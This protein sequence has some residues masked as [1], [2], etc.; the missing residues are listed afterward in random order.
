MRY[1]IAIMDYGIGGIDLV[2]RIKLTH[3]RLPILYFS[4]SGYTPY[5]K[6]PKKKLR[7]RV[8]EVIRFLQDKGAQ[9]IVVACH[10]ASSVVNGKNPDVLGI[11][12]L[13]IQS[14][15]KSDVNSVGVI[16]GGRT[17]RAQFYKNELK[18]NGL[19]V[20]QRIAQELSILIE[21]GE[22]DSDYT[23]K[24]LKRIID[25]LKHQEALLLACTH[26]PAL[27]DKIQKM[28]PVLKLID[29]KEEVVS[30]ITEHNWLESAG[31][32]QDQFF[33]SGNPILMK[34]AANKAFQFKIPDVKAIPI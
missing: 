26:Y 13:T 7:D 28:Y 24:T 25:P 9:R 29:P 32:I 5:G 17:I 34:E 22:L 2:R 21:R 31:Q 1:P 16:G 4:D 14:V 3:P 23:I 33:T 11:R 12:D 27:S 15:L 10:S 18:K 30:F 6:V 19:M 8:G 20:K